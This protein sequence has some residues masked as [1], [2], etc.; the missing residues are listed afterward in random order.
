MSPTDDLTSWTTLTTPTYCYAL[1]TYHSQLVLVGGR[2]VVTNQITNELVTSDTGRNWQPSLPPMPTKRY[3][4]SAIN[5]GTPECLVVAGGYDA[6]YNCLVTVELLQEWQWSTVQPLPKQCYVMRSALHD[7]K[8]YFGIAGHISDACYYYCEV[9]SLQ[10]LTQWSQ[11][12]VPSTT[13]HLVSF[14]QRLV[15]ISADAQILARSPVTQSW[16]EVGRKP[17]GHASA[18]PVVIPSGLLVMVLHKILSLTSS[19]SQLYITLLRG[20]RFHS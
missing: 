7:G 20:K 2:E 5:V 8:L 13:F 9:N 1:T 3:R 16:V 10:S 15:A 19:C 4:S 18:V 6:H 14:G 12:N 11:I 17:H